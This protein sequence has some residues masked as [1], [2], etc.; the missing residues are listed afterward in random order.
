MRIEDSNQNE[1]T[2]KAIKG[3]NQTSIDQDVCSFDLD[4]SDEE[5]A[6]FVNKLPRGSCI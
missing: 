2:F 1:A 3:K 4:V 6:G 5:L